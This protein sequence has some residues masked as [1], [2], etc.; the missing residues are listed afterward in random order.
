MS[1]SKSIPVRIFP[2]HRLMGAPDRIHRAGLVVEICILAAIMILFNYFPEKIGYYVTATDSRTFVPL[3]APAFQTHMPWLN[4]YWTLA[5]L[6]AGAKLVHGRWTVTLR[7][8][9]LGM[10]LLAIVVLWQLVQGGP[11]VGLQPG[12]VAPQDA[13]GLLFDERAV[14]A[15]NAGIKAALGLAIFGMLLPP[16]LRFLTVL[17]E[18]TGDLEAGQGQT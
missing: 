4:A 12:W 2:V 3:L 7:W 10:R 16:F 6:L 9:D 11:I 5:L 14:S 15:L 13:S 17:K 18:I 8:A 1:Q